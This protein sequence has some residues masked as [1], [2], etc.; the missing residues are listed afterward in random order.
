MGIREWEQ[1]RQKRRMKIWGIQI[2]VIVFFLMVVAMLLLNPLR[3]DF[4]GGSHRIIPTAVDTDV[5]GNYQV[6]FRT[7]N[8]TNNRQED[9]YYIDKDTP[10]L[11]KQVEEAIRNNKEIIVY[12]DRYIGW[13][14]FTAPKTSPILRI[15][16]T[17]DIPKLI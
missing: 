3:F 8:F 15:E 2:G 5:W 1:S 7:S 9:I 11:A 14:G 10:D 17:G 16:V 6:Y 13:K 4:A 12:Y